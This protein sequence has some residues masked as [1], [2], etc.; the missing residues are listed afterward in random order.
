MRMINDGK[1]APAPRT[2]RRTYNR[3]AP[4][5][6]TRISAYSALVWLLDVVAGTATAQ[7]PG[8]HPVNDAVFYGSPGLELTNPVSLGSPMVMPT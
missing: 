4:T 7:R 6:P 1:P 5:T 2:S 8:L 3:S